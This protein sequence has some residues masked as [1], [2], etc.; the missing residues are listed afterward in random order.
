MLGMLQM[1]TATPEPPREASQRPLD[2]N[3]NDNQSSQLE[4]APAFNL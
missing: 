4:Q 3:P 1:K 2:M